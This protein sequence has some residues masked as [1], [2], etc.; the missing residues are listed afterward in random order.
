[1]DAK[2]PFTV[3]LLP[4]GKS[5]FSAARTDYTQVQVMAVN[6]AD[7]RFADEVQALVRAGAH[8]VVEARPGGQEPPTFG[9][10]AVDVP[11]DEQGDP[12][13]E[14]GER[15]KAPRGCLTSVRTWWGEVMPT[16][17][18]DARDLQHNLHMAEQLQIS[19]R[20]SRASAAMTLRILEDLERDVERPR[21]MDLEGAIAAIEPVLA[22]AL[23][24]ALGKSS[25]DSE[26]RL[27]LRAATREIG[28]H[29]RVL[30]RLVREGRSPIPV[31]HRGPRL[32]FRRGDVDELLGGDP[33]RTE[34]PVARL[35]LALRAALPAARP[36]ARGLLQ[37]A[38][39]ADALGMR[40]TQ[41]WGLCTRGKSPLPVLKI[42]RR[43]F[44]KRGDV[45]AA[46][47]RM[48]STTSNPSQEST[49]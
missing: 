34:G 5:R 45:E 4:A 44:F 49:S 8:Y 33:A 9:P 19:R 41:L 23:A 21:S 39:A 12:G 18:E 16:L 36:G 43:F 35:A 26:E 6:D 27:S 40:P 25:G 14:V 37:T 10:V 32:F 17:D 38:A 30:A 11:T 24:A 20:L 31:E 1:M 22:P 48:K 15:R 2:Q 47:A 42:G 7:A 46:V 13:L 3:W 29:P 28:W